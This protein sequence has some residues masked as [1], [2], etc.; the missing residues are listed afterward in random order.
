MKKV[1]FNTSN[2]RV[3]EVKYFDVCRNGLEYTES[4]ISYVL[5]LRQ[6]DKYFNLL[7]PGEHF[8]V[9]E[10]VSDTTSRWGTEDYFGN[11][12]NL[13]DG[14]IQQGESWLLTDI[15]LSDAFLAS[16]VSIKELEDYVISSPM[17]FHNRK[18]IIKERLEGKGKA[19]L[20]ERWRLSKIASKDADNHARMN[21]FFSE[22][23]I[24]KVKK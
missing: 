6:D 15:D 5:L 8:S 9:Y 16:E 3:A 7:N 10:R 18:E 2:L 13:V 11:R 14:D 12:I 1:R 17:F 19:S 21:S 4:P 20:I 22:H 24:Q 23:G